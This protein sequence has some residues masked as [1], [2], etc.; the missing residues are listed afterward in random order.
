MNQILFPPTNEPMSQEEIEYRAMRREL[1]LISERTELEAAWKR[2]YEEGRE[3]AKKRG[4]AFALS[5][6]IANGIPE[7]EAR[8]LLGL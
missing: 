4:M 6:V 2:G 1:Q 5:R 3:E 7:A 8:A